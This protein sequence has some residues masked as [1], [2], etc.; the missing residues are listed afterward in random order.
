[1]SS[2]QCISN[3]DAN[4]FKVKSYS[5]F[6]DFCWLI[7]NFLFLK[8]YALLSYCSLTV[9]FVKINC[10]SWLNLEMI[11]ALGTGEALFNMST[12]KLEASL[13]RVEGILTHSD[14]DDW[15]KYKDQV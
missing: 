14:M 13:D 12:G 3:L 10:A 11:R 6:M 9:L 7:Y 2:H 5:F 15:Y 4:N 1:M 8:L